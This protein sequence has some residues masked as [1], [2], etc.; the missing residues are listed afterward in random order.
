[1]YVRTPVLKYVFSGPKVIC[2]KLKC[3]QT[4]AE[5]AFSSGTLTERKKS[6]FHELREKSVEVNGDIVSPLANY[7]Y[8]I[9]AFEAIFMGPIFWCIKIVFYYSNGYDI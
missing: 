6:P 4:F 2:E 1:M 3:I 7:A 9:E 5:I 8:A